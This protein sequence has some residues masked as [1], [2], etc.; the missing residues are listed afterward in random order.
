M[1]FSVTRRVGLVENLEPQ[2]SVCV[3]AIGVGEVGPDELV[4]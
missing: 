2:W 3:V 1:T 4:V